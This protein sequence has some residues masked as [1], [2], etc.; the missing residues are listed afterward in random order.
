MIAMPLV[1]ARLQWVLRSDLV[2]ATEYR[3]IVVVT[4]RGRPATMF[5]G[6]TIPGLTSHL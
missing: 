1:V 2:R 6:T 3:L 4:P 5:I